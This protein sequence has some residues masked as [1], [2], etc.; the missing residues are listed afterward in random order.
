M[1][2][3]LR[4]LLLFVVVAIIASAL[5]PLLWAPPPATRGSEQA[6]WQVTCDGFVGQA[7]GWQLGQTRPAEV[8]AKLGSDIEWALWQRPQQPVVLEGWI[9]D[10][11][12]AGMSGKLLLRFALPQELATEALASGAKPEVSPS[13]AVRLPWA[14]ERSAHWRDEPRL[15]LVGFLPGARLQETDLRQHFD[16]LG[17]PQREE[18]SDGIV[19]LSYRVACPEGAALVVRVL[20]PREGGRAAIEYEKA[21]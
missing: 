10:Y 20:V 17:T 15:V 4:H 1:K 14:P 6:P 7:L 16:R 2:V 8:I 3:R 5:L 12:A 11:L 19:H 13:G 9:Q 21:R 18:D